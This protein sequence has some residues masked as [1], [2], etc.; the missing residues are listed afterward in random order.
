MIPGRATISRLLALLAWP[1]VALAQEVP[2]VEAVGP[3]LLAEVRIAA[4]PDAQRREWSA[5]VATSRRLHAADTAAMHAELRGLH[6]AAM[7]RAPYLAPEFEYHGR[8]EAWLQ[9]DSG[10]RMVDAVLSFQTPSGGWSKRTDMSR[11]RA[12]GMSYYSET[13]DWH[14]IPTFDNGATTGQLRFLARATA[15]IADARAAAAYRR[16]LALLLAAQQPNGCWPQS[17]PLEGG[18]HD[19]ITFNDDATVRVLAT[20]DA[21][22]RGSI[23]FISPAERARAREAARRGVACLAAAQ[24]RVAGKATVWGQQHDPISLAVVPARK[25]EL[26]GLA[27]RESAAILSYL[28]TL[29]SPDASVVDAVHAAAEWFRAHGIPGFRYGGY[30]LSK[31]ASAGPIWARLTEIS[32]DRPIFSNRDAVRLYDWNQLT[33]RRSG[34]AWYGTE[35]AN[36]LS[37]Y[38]RWALLHPAP[39]P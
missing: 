25:Y 34:Y 39:A 10:R 2:A 20:L 31:D 22:A 19:A 6:Q 5:Y 23:E 26:A 21:A 12:A 11:P 28:M 9:S 37:E 14:Y 13:P 27:G 16:G 4:L 1:A 29:P 18:Y 15:V 7:I 30:E 24:V 38:A 33:D 36:A 8:S 32:T 3:A 35:P 17:Y